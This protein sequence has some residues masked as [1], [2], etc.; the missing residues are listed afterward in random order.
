MYNTIQGGPKCKPLSSIIIKSYCRHI[1]VL[2]GDIL[3]ARLP[4]LMICI[5]FYISRFLNSLGN[6]CSLLKVYIYQQCYTKSVQRHSSCF[7]F[8]HLQSVVVS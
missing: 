4:G 2:L 6:I 5:K 7:T 1:G 3:P 8:S